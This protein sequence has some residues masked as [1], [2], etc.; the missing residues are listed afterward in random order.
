MATTKRSRQ[1]VKAMISL[2]ACAMLQNPVLVLAALSLGVTGIFCYAAVFWA[3]PS[4]MLT[5]EAG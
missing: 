5:P 4:S 3:V 2:V 1:F